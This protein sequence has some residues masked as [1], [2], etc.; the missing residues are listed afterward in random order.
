MDWKG[1]FGVPD[2]V[3]YFDGDEFAAGLLYNF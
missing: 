1:G 3:S 2:N